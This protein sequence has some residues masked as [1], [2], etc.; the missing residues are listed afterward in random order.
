MNYTLITRVRQWAYSPSWLGTMPPEVRPI[1]RA[2]GLLR[3][4]ELIKAR[5][6]FSITN[7][8]KVASL[9]MTKLSGRL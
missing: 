3:S 6:F 9:V 1:Y 7:R 5:T 4:L 8:D 2:L